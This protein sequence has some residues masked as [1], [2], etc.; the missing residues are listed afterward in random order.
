MND[1]AE[2]LG[3]PIPAQSSADKAVERFIK[4]HLAADLNRSPIASRD[5]CCHVCHREHPRS[6]PELRVFS[7][8]NLSL[9]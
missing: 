3:D 7:R 5:K 4:G 1:N 2:A 9:R 8:H 6:F